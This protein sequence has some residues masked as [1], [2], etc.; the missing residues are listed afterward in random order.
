MFDKPNIWS[1]DRGKRLNFAISKEPR[2]VHNMCLVNYVFETSPCHC[3]FAFSFMRHPA[4]NT[5]LVSIPCTL[6]RSIFQKQ[7]LFTKMN[8]Q[9]KVK[10]WWAGGSNRSK[11]QKNWNFIADAISTQNLTQSQ[12]GE[13][14]WRRM[15]NYESN[16]GT[17][18]LAKSTLC[19]FLEALC[20][21]KQ[22][23]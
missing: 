16:I 14:G 23:K 19:W 12:Q 7:R 18:C 6:N 22:R 15:T 2:Q 13:T 1:F 10:N 20:Q 9:E 11:N 5:F 8:F 4:E 17:A 3:E 21:G